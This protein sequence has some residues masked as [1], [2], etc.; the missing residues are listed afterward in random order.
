MGGSGWDAQPY[1]L[2]SGGLKL[3]N[4]WPRKI[5]VLNQILDGII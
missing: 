3:C 2:L 5:I 4:V 1:R